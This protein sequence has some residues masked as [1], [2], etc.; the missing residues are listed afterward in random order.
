MEND[1]TEFRKILSNYR[2]ADE[3]VGLLKKS[4]LVLLVSPSASGRNTI[5][6]ELIKKDVYHYLVSDTTRLPRVN[7]G[8]L[9]KNG[10]QY[11]FRTLDGF[12]S[13]LKNGEY[14]EAAIVHNQQVSGM[15]KKELQ[16][17]VDTDK[18]ALKDIDIQG[19]ETIYSLAP[20][21]VCLFILPPSYEE[22][23][24]RLDNRGDMSVIEKQRR[25]QS[26]VV[27]LRHALSF[28][29]YV[30]VVNDNLELVV[31][32]IHKILTTNKVDPISQ[33]KGREV[34]KDI[35][36]KAESKISLV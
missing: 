18:F 23:L 1:F 2:V 13:D 32:Q 12:L 27:E 19:A 10:H 6:R 29:N 36:K 20:N 34:A 11:W 24:K 17:A 3:T 16:Y 9:E 21:V 22:W 35:L 31:E 26:A 5:V 30:Y 28:K 25:L 14:I 33:K 15:N 4:K 8:V 7:D